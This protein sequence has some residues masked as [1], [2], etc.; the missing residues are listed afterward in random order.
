MATPSF[1]RPRA[2][3][4][5]VCLTLVTAPATSVAEEAVKTTTA[6][7]FVGTTPYDDTLNKLSAKVTPKIFNGDTAA[8]G[9]YPWQVALIVSPVDDPLRGFFCSGAIYSNSWVVTAAHCMVRKE[10][11]SLPGGKLLALTPDQVRI[12][13]GV[14]ALQANLPQQKV[15]RIVMHDGFSWQ[16]F[17]NDIALIQLVNPIAPSPLAKPIPVLS[18]AEEADVLKAG[19]QLAVTGWGAT[20]PA[21]EHAGLAVRQL[22][23]GMVR[24]VPRDT[25]VKSLSGSTITA[26][27]I[28]TFSKFV[29]VCS[30]DSGGPIVPYRS[31]A[32][33]KLV[34]I[35]S[36]NWVGDC[37]N[38][39]FQRHTRVVS[40]AAWI[41][42][43]SAAPETCG[44]W[45]P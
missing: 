7:G 22:R 29:D 34:G 24:F 15:A 11:P 6:S 13:Y 39:D 26:N 30:G 33:A 3:A 8:D 17:D 43:C 2:L 27:M 36:G 16:T 1:R 41:Q 31:G 18:G 19:A 45:K 12:V 21:G 9:A 28:C 37:G 25:C 20:S 35:V 38:N 23:D 32:D 40:F 14:N 10:T 42:K 4:I 5:G 44:T